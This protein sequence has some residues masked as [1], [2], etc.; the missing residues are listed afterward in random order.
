MRLKS[1]AVFCFTPFV[2]GL[3]MA[4]MHAQGII[5]GSINGTVQDSTGAI[6][7]GAKITAL[8]TALGQTFTLAATNSGEF[9][10]SSLPIGD[11]T[12]TIA[13]TGFGELKLEHLQ[14]ETGKTLGLGIEKLQTG[15]AAET[16]EVSTARNLLETTQSQVTTTF[17][18]EMIQDLPTGGGLDQLALLVP[19]VAATHGSNFSNNNGGGFSSNGQRGRSNNFEIDGQANNDNSVGGSQIFF[20]NEDAV[21]EVQVITNNF[22]AEYGR[23]MGSIVNY[24]TKSG[25]NSIHGSGFEYY[26]GNFLSSMRASQKSPY[27]SFNRCLPGSTTVPAGCTPAK[28]P[29]FSDNTYGGTLGFPILKDKLF[30]FGST[31][32]SRNLSGA[33][34]STSGAAYFPTPAGLSQLQAALP[35]NR[36]V[37]ELVNFGPYAA[38][39]GTVTNTGTTINE[40]ITVPGSTVPISVPFSQITRTYNPQ[41]FDQEHLGRLD[42]QA[43]QKDRFFLRYFYQ[44]APSVFAG[45]TF[46]SGA[47]YNTGATSHSIGSD[48]THT[49]GPRWVNQIRYSFQQ[50]TFNFDGGGFLIA[51]SRTWPPAPPRPLSAATSTPIRAPERQ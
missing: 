24:V 3:G 50:S 33:Q 1:L 16:V 22:S 10:F 6:I 11:Y 39:G 21:Q 49:F 5:T 14:V 36:G 13:Q 51:R 41:S 2:L 35:G 9:T 19:G 38:Q 17:D 37:A 32:W 44:N 47:Y 18:S 8:N 26:T 45:G 15:G 7:P 48:W 30:A 12:V 28:L 27:P 34:V 43:T 42:F 46:S 4:R 40:L 31:L 25:T 23:N 29:R 20:Q